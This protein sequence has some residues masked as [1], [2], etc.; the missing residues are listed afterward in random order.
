VIA[1]QARLRQCDIIKTDS[2]LYLIAPVKEASQ[3]PY[4]VR[5]FLSEESLL[6]GSFVY[7]NGVIIDINKRLEEERYR[8]G[9]TRILDRIVTLER[10]LSDNI[11]NLVRQFDEFHE[12][13]LKPMVTR[14]LEADGS[15]I[16]LSIDSRM[17][18]F[19]EQLEKEILTRV[20]HAIVNIATTNDDYE[21]L[22]F[23]L[24]R[25]LIELA[26]EVRDFASDAAVW[27]QRVEITELK[28][29]ALLHLLDKRKAEIFTSVRSDEID[30][31][32][33]PALLLKELHFSLKK[34]GAEI[35]QLNIE[36]RDALDHQEEMNRTGFK[37]WLQRTFSFKGKSSQVQ[38][39]ELRKKIQSA[40]KKCFLA[41]IRTFKQYPKI[42]IYM[43]FEE[44][45]PVIDGIRHYAIAQGVMG[46]SELPMMLRLQEDANT[47]DIGAI[48]KV[49]TPRN[50]AR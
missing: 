22:F 14:S 21:Y 3:N 15:A 4:S 9:I 2:L 20:D 19:E 29:I 5:R 28:I 46:V 50:K 49:L 48:T 31:E 18:D 33:E 27:S 38:P 10:Q 1:S 23:S 11:V 36:L 39:D 41:L 37:A 16:G 7:F 35:S 6:G 42:R 44:V 45:T 8:N 25:I 47:F 26:G 17:E 32:N 40:R 13:T 12:Q 30:P 43:E 24:R 34:Y